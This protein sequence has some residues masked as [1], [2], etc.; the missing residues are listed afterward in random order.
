M[1]LRRRAA[2]LL[3]LYGQRA[4]VWLDAGPYGPRTGP[5]GQATGKY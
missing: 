2:A 1:R 3:A 4:G 5:P